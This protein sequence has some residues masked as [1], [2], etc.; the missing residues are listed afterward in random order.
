MVGEAAGPESARFGP[1]TTGEQIVERARYPYPGYFY[2][3]SLLPGYYGEDEMASVLRIVE[4]G[5]VSRLRAGFVA[6]LAA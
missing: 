5:L 2:L 4:E 3:G 6:D 1:P